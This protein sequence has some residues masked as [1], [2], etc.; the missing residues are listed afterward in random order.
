ME[1]R[2]ARGDG[3]HVLGLEVGGHPLLEQRGARP[4][5]QPA[6]PQ[7]LDDGGDLLLP[8]RGR[9]E[10]E[11]GAT[12]GSHRPGSVRPAPHGEPAPGRRRGRRPSRGSR[13]RGRR[14][15]A[16]ARSATRAAGT[17]APTRRPRPP[18]PPRLPPSRS[19]TPSGATRKRTHAPPTRRRR[20]WL[21]TLAH[22]RLAE[23]ERD[24]E[25][26]E[27]DADGG[28]AELRVVAAAEP[29]RDLHDVRPAVGAEPD[30]GVARAVLDPE[31][32][33]RGAR[34]L[35]HARRSDAR[36]ARR[37]RGRRRTRAARRGA[38]R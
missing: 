18:R 14:R 9:L 28:A 30:L 2:R 8:D 24:G 6:R 11:P 12:R 19:S 37:A 3:E 33:D 15:G 23:R 38:C 31:R 13:R 26:V 5:R 35:D 27:V 21:V 17:S 4:G 22:D 20:S 1:R 25:V 36:S 29:R 10:A 32:R 34:R 16:A 7:G